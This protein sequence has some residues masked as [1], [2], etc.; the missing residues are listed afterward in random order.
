MVPREKH[1]GQY[2]DRPCVCKSS[3]QTLV[4]DVSELCDCCNVAYLSVMLMPRAAHVRQGFYWPAAWLGSP[5]SLPPAKHKHPI[6]MALI[7]PSN[8]EATNVQS[9]RTQRFL[10]I[11]QT[12]SCWY[13]LDSS[14]W[15]LSDE[16]PCARVFLN[17][18]LVKLQQFSQNIWRKDFFRT[19]I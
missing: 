12:L 2:F 15:A 13:S 6:R 4:D 14:W 16:Y 5:C 1:D 7:N 17:F 11:I 19:L 18:V 3:L 10:K 8:A 9:T